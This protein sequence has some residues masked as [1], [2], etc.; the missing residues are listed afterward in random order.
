[1]NE[2][3]NNSKI[4]ETCLDLAIESFNAKSLGISSVI[5]D[6]NNNIIAIGSNQI[7]DKRNTCNK[8]FM[9]SIA[10]AE[11]NAIHN[12]GLIGMDGKNFILFTTVEPCPMCMGAISLSRIRKVVIGSKDSYAGS[13]DW[14][15]SNNYINNKNIEIIFE[16]NSYE[17]LFFK[18]HYL[19]IKRELR[20]RPNHKIFDSFK[21][22]YSKELYEVEKILMNIQ[23]N[24]L[25]ID[26]EWVE[27]YMF[28]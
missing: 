10:H 23:I 24:D 21:S 26:R 25:I 13:T 20:N 6:I 17:R 27:K 15:K 19:S 22:D 2:L 5:T 16:N 4:W 3:M 14:M 9:S 28:I 1:M 11:I 18:L 7:R 8:V 12:L